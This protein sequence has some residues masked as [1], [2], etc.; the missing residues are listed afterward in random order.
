MDNELLEIAINLR[1]KYNKVS[2]LLDITQQMSGC[3]SRNDMVSFKIYLKMRTDIL[4]EIEE[5]NNRR[6][7]LVAALEPQKA[8][9]ARYLMQKDMVVPDDLSAEDLKLYSTFMDC[10]S[11]AAKLVAI[12]K[13][14]SK[15]ICGDKSFYKK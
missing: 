14:M 9:R 10:K 13:V 4:L 7:Q 1:K 8:Q 12:D 6:E 11:A 2:E 15:K 5:I 3:I